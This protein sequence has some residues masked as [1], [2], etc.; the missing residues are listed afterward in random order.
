MPRAEPAVPKHAVPSADSASE[1]D[2]EQP[3]KTSLPTVYQSSDV[4]FSRWRK[5][6]RPLGGNDFNAI[7]SP[8]VHAD[9]SGISRVLFT[10]ARTA[11]TLISTCRSLLFLLQLSVEDQL[12]LIRFVEFR[13]KMSKR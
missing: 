11:A 13:K 8:P 10:R 3:G 4:V 1:E 5:L 7:D 12:S 9:T 6:M 2:Q